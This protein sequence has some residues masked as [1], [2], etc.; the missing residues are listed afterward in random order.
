MEVVIYYYWRHDS[1]CVQ[2]D[3]SCVHGFVIYKPT[4]GVITT[5]RS[6]GLSQNRFVPTSRE[7]NE[8]VG[9]RSVDRTLDGSCKHSQTHNPGEMCRRVVR[10]VAVDPGDK[11]G[12]Q[13]T[14]ED[15]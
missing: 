10:P 11:R 15:A 4:G 12:C 2:G 8:I 9:N 14:R 5:W 1:P 7:L 3:S 6:T 13:P